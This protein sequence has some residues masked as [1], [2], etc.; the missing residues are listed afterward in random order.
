MIEADVAPGEACFSMI[1]DPAVVRQATEAGV[2][3]VFEATLGGKCGPRQGGPIRGEARVMAVTTGRYT[4]RPGSMFAGVKFDVGPM[5]WLRIRN[6][7][8][9]VSSRPEQMYDDEPFLLH[10][11]NIGQ[12]RIVGI[13]GANHFRAGYGPL[14]GRMI[15]ADGGGLSSADLTTF[16]RR[17]NARPLWPLEDVDFNPPAM[18]DG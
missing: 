8:V 17:S 5:C 13:K 15:A 18:R 4:C 16:P 14:S 7:D 6:V 10:G 2:G 3:Q 11:I 1:A 12:Y 9:L